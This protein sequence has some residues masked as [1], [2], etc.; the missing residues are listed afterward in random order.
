MEAEIVDIGV[1]FRWFKTPRCQR[2]FLAVWPFLARLLSQRCA[3][4]HRPNVWRHNAAD[5][6]WLLTASVAKKAPSRLR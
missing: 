5:P 2:L 1:A 3:R 4:P 6:K